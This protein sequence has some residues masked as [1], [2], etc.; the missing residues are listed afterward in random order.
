[1]ASLLAVVALSASAGCSSDDQK[2]DFAIPKE[3]C[4]VAVQA[5]PL[6]RLLPASGK[7][8]D[9][10]KVAPSAESH[11]TCDVTVDGNVVLTVEEEHIKSGRSAWIIASYDHGIGHVKSSDGGS[12]A[13]VGRAAVSVV[14]CT[15]KGIRKEAVST[16][17]RLLKP[18]RQDDSSMR[19]LIRAYTESLK[20]LQPCGTGS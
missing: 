18:G 14:P 4:G 15:G 2:R 8:L 19:Q 3:L 7:R 12:I 20:K 11:A 10:E 9:V 16:Y 17:I 6:T 13:Y 1:M 5:G